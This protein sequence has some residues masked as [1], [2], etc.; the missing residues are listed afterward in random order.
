MYL[1]HDREGPIIDG[2]PYDLK[3]PRRTGA[4]PARFNPHGAGR[5]S[6][7]PTTMVDLQRRT[8]RY[9]GRAK[10]HAECSAISAWM[11]RGDA[12]AAIEAAGIPYE[13]ARVAVPLTREAREHDRGLP[14]LSGKGAPPLLCGLSSD[15]QQEARRTSNEV[16]RVWQ[17]QGCPYLSAKQIEATYQH[18]VAVV[19]AGLLPPI[20][21]LNAEPAPPANFKLPMCAEF[22][23][24]LGD[25]IKERS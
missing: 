16:Y 5:I 9:F 11:M 24:R 2:H 6:S 22:L 4:P 23:D 20:P 14:K 8:G 10:T 3:N 25:R 1:P 15:C 21:G 12:T 13:V 18:L 17:D 7:Q 19:R